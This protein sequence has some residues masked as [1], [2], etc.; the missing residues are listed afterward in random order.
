MTPELPFPY[1]QTMTDN[2]LFLN[3]FYRTGTAG[4]PLAYQNA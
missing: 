2:Y 1:N 3:A 4:T